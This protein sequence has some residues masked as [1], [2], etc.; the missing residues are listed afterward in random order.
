[1]RKFI[2]IAALL[3]TTAAFAVPLPPKRPKDL[4]IKTATLPEWKPVIVHSVKPA[5]FQDVYPVYSSNKTFLEKY[6]EFFW[7]EKTFTD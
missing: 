4:G 5:T 6:L 2:V 3:A 1:M 7:L